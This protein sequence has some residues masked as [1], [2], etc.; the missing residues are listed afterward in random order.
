MSIPATAVIIFAEGKEFYDPSVM[1]IL[2]QYRVSHPL[3]LG[4]ASF[5]P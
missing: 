1:R 4:L 5:R 2:F 3:A